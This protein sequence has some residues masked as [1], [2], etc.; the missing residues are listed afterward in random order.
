MR[1]VDEF[2]KIRGYWT[3][4]PFIISNIRLFTDQESWMARNRWKG[5]RVGLAIFGAGGD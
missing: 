2:G 1:L 4:N 3:H 5:P